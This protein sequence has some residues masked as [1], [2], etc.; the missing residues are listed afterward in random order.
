MLNFL[1]FLNSI[2]ISAQTS[3]AAGGSLEECQQCFFSMAWYAQTPA[4]ATILVALR[5]HATGTA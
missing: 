3:G 1:S 2:E 5:R 4:L